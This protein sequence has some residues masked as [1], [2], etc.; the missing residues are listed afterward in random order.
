[1]RTALASIPVAAALGRLHIAQLY[2]V[3]FLVGVGTLFFDV[4]YQSYL[5]SLVGREQLVEGNSK[6]EASSAVAQ[7]AGP[8]LAGGLVQIITAPLA[9]V[10][11]A[12]SFL[13]SVLTLIAIRTKETPPQSGTQQRLGGA[14]REG[15][16]VLFGHPLLR[17]LA[18]SAA[19]ANFGDSVI[20]AV[21]VLFVTRTLG[22]SAGLLGLIFAGGSV[23]SLL[24]AL[25]AGKIASRFG[26]GR[27]F[28]SG[29]ILVG[30]GSLLLPVARGPAII[31]VPLLIAAWLISGFGLILTRV[32]NVSLRQRIV[33]DHM[34]G[35]VNASI[36]FITWGV[37]PIGNLIG[38]ALGEVIGLRLTLLLGAV[39]MCA[40]FS[41][42]VFSPLR[43]LREPPSSVEELATATSV[44][45]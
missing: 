1:M 37:L 2:V 11:D 39:T 34:Q 30:L 12:L 9:L 5:P 29:A 31:T 26:L 35:R 33:P 13:A 28:V 18:L 41:F 19:L 16:R 25:L 42:I 44:P 21:F 45:D 7:I 3:G 22:L 14:I 6:L 40:A 10:A 38:G 23:G 8:G 24:G 20:Y 32:N 15:L 4:A 36:R 27:I 43:L 17:P